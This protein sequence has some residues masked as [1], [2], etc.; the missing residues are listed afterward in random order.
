MMVEGVQVYMKKEMS[1]VL[2]MPSF[3]VISKLLQYVDY[4]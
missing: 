1:K 3:L 4:D 2:A